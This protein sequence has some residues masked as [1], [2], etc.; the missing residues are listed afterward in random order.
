[1]SLDIGKIEEAAKNVE[2]ERQKLQDLMEKRTQ[3]YVQQRECEMVLEEFEFLN[4]TDVVMKRNGPI[5]VKQDFEDAKS[6]IQNTV[7]IIKEQLQNCDKALEQQQKALVQAE[8]KLQEF[9]PKA[10]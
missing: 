10:K 8:K 7:S 5:L 1:M 3:I 4:E 2:Q 6:E 9:Q